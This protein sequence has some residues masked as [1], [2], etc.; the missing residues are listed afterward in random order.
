MAA[1]TK[2]SQQLGRVSGEQEYSERTCPTSD[3]VI[4]S[5]ERNFE[6]N[7]KP[8]W[9]EWTKDIKIVKYGYAAAKQ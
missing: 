2:E 5:V 3:E 9:I 4:E 1:K 7:V 8:A 6:E